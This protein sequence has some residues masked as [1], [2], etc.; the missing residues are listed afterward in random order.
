MP[1]S[2]GA[3][4]TSALLQPIYR[5]STTE[6]GIALPKCSKLL[7]LTT[8]FPALSNRKEC[9]LMRQVGRDGNT[10]LDGS[11]TRTLL[12]DWRFTPLRRVSNSQTHLTSFFGWFLKNTFNA[13]SIYATTNPSCVVMLFKVLTSAQATPSPSFAIHFRMEGP[14]GK[15][16]DVE[17][18]LEYVRFTTAQ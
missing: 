12:V 7:H 2:L 14:T 6:D 15:V 10:Y 18:T 16:A 17:C 13:V 11:H 4:A 3:R 5:M 9:S 8:L 1:L